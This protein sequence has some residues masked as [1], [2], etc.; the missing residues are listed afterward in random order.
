[1]LK[2]LDSIPS[3]EIEERKTPKALCSKW[4]RETP[5]WGHYKSL[6]FS[7]LTCTCKANEVKGFITFTQ[8]RVGQCTPW[9]VLWKEC[10]KSAHLKGRSHHSKEH[11]QKHFLASW[12]ED[13]QRTRGNITNASDCHQVTVKGKKEEELVVWANLITLMQVLVCVDLLMS[14]RGRKG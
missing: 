11:R 4:R 9:R 12:I 3:P 10:Q 14:W 13:K 7:F 5:L 6:Q 8:C 1:M 2:A